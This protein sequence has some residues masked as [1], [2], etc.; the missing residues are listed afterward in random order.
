[1]Q[2]ADFAI[3]AATAKVLPVA[4]GPARQRGSRDAIHRRHVFGELA[5]LEGLH[6]VLARQQFEGEE[7]LRRLL[8]EAIDLPIVAAGLRRFRDVGVPEEAVGV[9][10]DVA[11]ITVRRGIR[12][13]LWFNI[14]RFTVRPRRP[15]VLP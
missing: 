13:R 1:M 10:H 5:A 11:E 9:R 15:D 7:A 12:C 8:V 14:H 2:P 3:R 6:V 4:R